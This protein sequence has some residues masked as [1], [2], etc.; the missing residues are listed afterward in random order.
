MFP[1]G[2]FLLSRYRTGPAFFILFFICWWDLGVAF[3]W[4]RRKRL[5]VGAFF[6]PACY[7]RVILGGE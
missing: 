3:P 4:S 7:E 6:F 5:V 1:R 2:E